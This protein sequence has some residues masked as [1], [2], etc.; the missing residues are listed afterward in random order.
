MEENRESNS[1]N[2]S[3]TEYF[4]VWILICLPKDIS[5]IFFNLFGGTGLI[6]NRFTT[7]GVMIPLFLWA[8]IRLKKF[9]FKSFFFTS[10]IEI[11]PGSGMFLTWSG[12][13]IYLYLKQK[14]EENVLK[15]I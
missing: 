12:W 10:G 13:I 14:S 6:I 15:R 4:L 2:I 11:T 1:S 7:I 9:P 8:I 3:L 5:D